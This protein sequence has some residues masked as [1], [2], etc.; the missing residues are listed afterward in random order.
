MGDP[1][2]P[3]PLDDVK[4]FAAG[5]ETETLVCR[6]SSHVWAML[7]SS[8]RQVDHD[9]HWTTDCEQCGTVRTVIYTTSG[10]LKGRR[11]EYPEGYRREGL[12]RIDIHGKAMMRVEMFRRMVGD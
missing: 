6:S 11:Y 3:A 8:V 1:P 12:G 7:T 9:L 5:L 10:Y 2:R 4:Q